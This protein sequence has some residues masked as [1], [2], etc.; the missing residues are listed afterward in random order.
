[1]LFRS[2]DTSKRPD[3]D[4]A[5]IRRIVALLPGMRHE[6]AEATAWVGFALAAVCYDVEKADEL[7][8]RSL[9]ANGNLPRTLQQKAAVSVWRGEHEKGMEFG[10]RAIALNPFDQA[11]FAAQL[12]VGHALLGLGR[13]AEAAAWFTKSLAIHPNWMQGVRAAASAHALSG[14]LDEA[15]HLV[16]RLLE[17]A[18]GMTVSRSRDTMHMRRPQDNERLLE[19]LRL[20]GLPE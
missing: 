18:P 1:M 12:N 14:N 17:I 11:I 2:Q 15:R 3:E 20:A 19:G 6:D 7:I 13:P 16:R 5:E 9:V 10:L 4:R 8:N